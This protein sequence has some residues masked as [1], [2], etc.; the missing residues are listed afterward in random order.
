[1]SKRGKAEATIGKAGLR[2]LLSHFEH[3]DFLSLDD[4]YDHTKN[5]P[6]HWTDFPSAVISLTIDGKTK[7]VEHYHGCR[8]LKVLDDLS[9]LEDH[10]DRV[11]GS[12]RWVGR[13]SR[14]SPLGSTH[15]YSN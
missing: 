9:E 2:D 14:E 13:Y 4:N 6:D 3:V 12:K 8:G 10:V 1:V 5:C 15:M 7:S 11:A